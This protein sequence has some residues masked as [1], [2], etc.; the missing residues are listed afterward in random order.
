MKLDAVVKPR[1]DNNIDLKSKIFTC[2]IPIIS[3]Y[4]SFKVKARLI[5]AK[6]A[7]IKFVIRR[8]VCYASAKAC[9]SSGNTLS[10]DILRKFDMY[11]AF[12]IGYSA[13]NISNTTIPQ[14]VNSAK[15]F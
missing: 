11:C 8:K 4:T 3:T 10:S 6:Y 5:T 1:Q 2:N 9:A 7:V 14:I 13:A 12:K 15:P